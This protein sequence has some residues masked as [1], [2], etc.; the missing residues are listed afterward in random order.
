M[1]EVSHSYVDKLPVFFFNIAT[2][3]VNLIKFRFIPMF[4]NEQD[5]EPMVNF[6]ANKYNSFKFGDI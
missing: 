3:G 1:R 5:F 6:E 2:H 4:V